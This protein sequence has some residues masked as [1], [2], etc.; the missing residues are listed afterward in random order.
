M[1]RKLMATFLSCA[2][3][4]ASLSTSAWSATN[5]PAAVAPQSVKTV[6]PAR[7]QAPLPPAG[8]ASS[9]AEAQG[10]IRSYPIISIAIAAGVVALVW[11]LLDEDDDAA[12]TGT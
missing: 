10:F 1:S 5:T 12:S 9:I 8:A 6:D 3:A 4:F 7:N 11:I 2:L